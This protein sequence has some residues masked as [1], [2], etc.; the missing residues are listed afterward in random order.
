MSSAPASR[1]RLAFVLGALAMFG[2]FS[3]DTVFPAFGAMAADLG[4]TPLAVQ[5]RRMPAGVNLLDA[6][7]RLGHEVARWR[8]AHTTPA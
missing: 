7:G 4:S 5:Q 1:A 2:P 6:L 8:A 3:I